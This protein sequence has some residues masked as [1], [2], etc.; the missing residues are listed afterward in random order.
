M[1]EWQR[2]TNEAMQKPPD[3]NSIAALTARIEALGQLL[4]RQ[5][6]RLRERDA[7]IEALE[8]ALREIVRGRLDASRVARTALSQ[9]QT[10]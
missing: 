2:K 9:D 7:R 10:K 3:Q 5:A 6:G 8:K 1:D 4:D